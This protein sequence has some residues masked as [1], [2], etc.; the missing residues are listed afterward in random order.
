MDRRTYL[1]T[2]GAASLGGVAGCLGGGNPNTTLGEPDR[3]DGVTSEA[4]SYPAWGEQIPDVTLPDPLTGTGIGLRDVD[5]PALVSFFYSNCMSVCPRLISALREV[6]IHSV[7]NDYAD[8]V[9]FY[10]I[11]FDPQRDTGERLREYAG[12]MNVEL[13]AGNWHF[14]RPESRER[15]KRV[16]EEEFGFVFQ[17]TEPE[18]GGKYMFNH[19]GL[20]I[21]VNADGYVERAYRGQEGKE[22]TYIEDLKK[23]RNGGG[24]FL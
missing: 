13:D 8:D 22:G 3:P 20:V 24:G 18:D 14:L 5:R 11:T 15:A 7:N 16:L 17:R 6:Q 9:G 12:E 4:L 19:I 1:G 21:L 10:P 2:L 23:V